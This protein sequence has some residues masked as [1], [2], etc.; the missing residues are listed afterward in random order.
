MRNLTLG[1]LLCSILIGIAGATLTVSNP[2]IAIGAT[3]TLTAQAGG[4]VPPYTFNFLVYSPSNV[5][6]FSNTVLANPNPQP[7]VLV[8]YSNGLL[9]GY[10]ATQNTNISRGM[11]LIEADSNAVNGTTLYLTDVLPKSYNISAN[12][13]YLSGSSFA[14][15]NISMYG[16]GKRDTMIIGGALSTVVL[17]TNSVLGDLDIYEESSYPAMPLSIDL[18]PVPV[19]NVI[20]RNIKING[21][22]NTVAFNIY[23]DSAHALTANVYNATLLS[24]MENILDQT[25]TG[26]NVLI[27]DSN[28]I[29]YSYTAAGNSG[30]NAYGIHEATDGT[31]IVVNSSF[32][33]QNGTAGGITT[34]LLDNFGTD[35]NVYIYNSV[36]FA[37]STNAMSLV[38]GIYSGGTVYINPSTIYNSKFGTI[39][40]TLGAYGTYTY[41][42]SPLPPPGGPYGTNST[43]FSYTQS[44]PT[45]TWN[46][47]L[48]VKDSTGNII[49]TDPTYNVIP[50]GTIFSIEQGH[51]AVINN[52]GA[53]GGNA[54]YSYQWLY[55]PPPCNAYAP[56]A[57]QNP[58]DLNATKTTYYFNT[59]NLTALGISCFVLQVTDASSAVA[60]SPPVGVDVLQGTPTVII[61]DDPLSALP[62]GIGIGLTVGIVFGMRKNK[63]DKLGRRTKPNPKK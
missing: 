43:A 36:F 9:V 32:N 41:N 35:N 7:D 15:H 60:N 2:T 44:A 58:P 39:S 30:Q 53:S 33:A 54:P 13:V 56:I 42:P 20:I 34:G 6:E 18:P 29:E 23:L 46:A 40:N 57:T 17:G 16:A 26:S 11:A 50:G 59:N 45:G 24:N 21:T 25:P 27:F 52:P 37:A 12:T 38:Y 48:I 14:G 62:F 49:V 63:G 61:S 22:K 3:Q 4:G 28:M 1:I 10:N 19:T 55:S 5:L 8:Q 51:T 47:I 31:L